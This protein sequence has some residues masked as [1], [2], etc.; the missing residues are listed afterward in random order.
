MPRSR[1][2]LRAGVIGTG[3]GRYHMEGFATHPGSELVAVCDLNAGEARQ[4]A[5]Q[6]G[7]KHVFRNYR[8]MVAMEGL[9][10]VAVA[11]PNNLHAPMTLAAL[12]AGKDVL[13]EKPMAIRLSHAEAMVR[14]ARRR[15]R[16]LMINV[17]MRFNPLH[18]EVHRRIGRGDLGEVYYAKSHWIRRKGIPFAD[19]PPTGDMARGE[20][21]VDKRKAGGG[22]SV[23][24]GVHLYDLVWWLIGAPKPATVL[25]STYSELLPD[26]LAKVGVKGDVDDLAAAFV[27]FRTGQ[28]LFL[29]VTWD[30]H[31]PPDLGYEVFGTEAGAVWADWGDTATLY[32]DTRSGRPTEKK[33]RASRKATSSYWHF[34]DCCLDRRKKMIASGEELLE[35]TRVLDGIARSQKTKK[36]VEL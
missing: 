35:V 9:D 22:A 19:F 25:A 3:M 28:T 6:Y 31:Q 29:E 16:R 14:E 30:A 10:L 11:T 12:R 36:A 21:F 34:V 4:F 20:W 26:R 5:D 32:F 17:G 18:Q 13:C 23:D 8:D 1:K 33:V 24:I 27:K 7:A 2:K 15:K